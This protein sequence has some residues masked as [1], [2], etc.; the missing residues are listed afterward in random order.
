MQDFAWDPLSERAGALHPAL[1]PLT[2]VSSHSVAPSPMRWPCS[3]G[4][5]VASVFSPLPSQ[6]AIV[7]LP[8]ALEY[9]DNEHIHNPSAV[10][11]TMAMFTL[12]EKPAPNDETPDSATHTWVEGELWRIIQRPL[13][14]RNGTQQ[15][16]TFSVVG[17]V[18]RVFFPTMI[19]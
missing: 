16:G 17:H 13:F 9:F 11:A 19:P 12:I 18:L 2:T 15:R 4:A 5:I 8:T 7:E 3:M 1:I 10:E 6:W 14:N